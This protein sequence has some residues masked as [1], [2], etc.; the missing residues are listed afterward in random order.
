MSADSHSTALLP[1]A[2]LVPTAQGVLAERLSKVLEGLDRPQ[3]ALDDA[4]TVHQ[5]RVATRRADAALRLFAPLLPR[6]RRRKV[7][8]ALRRLRRAAG[9]VRDCDVHLAQAAERRQA[10]PAALARRLH[11]HRRQAL[12]R[13]RKLRRRERRRLKRRVRKL[14]ARLAWRQKAPPPGYAAWC[15]AR[16]DLLAQRLFTWAE[17]KSADDDALHQLRI[18]GKRLRYALELVAPA[19][20]GPSV[21][22]MLAALHTLQD[23]LGRLCDQRAAVMHLT[24]A[25]GSASDAATRHAFAAE[26]KAQERRLAAQRRALFRWWTAARQRRLAQLWQKVRD[27]GVRR[28][29]PARRRRR[30]PG[31]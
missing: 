8:K 14:L 17:Q 9:A 31:G 18:A 30:P 7:Q 20:T 21:Q 19:L 22:Q 29:F 26:R 3:R 24:E 15:L 5:L 27:E 25:E 13:L 23:R 11:R 12:K 1:G 2:P 10:I 6:R 4:E 28:V 16:C